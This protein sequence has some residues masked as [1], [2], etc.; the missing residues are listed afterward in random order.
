M[1]SNVTPTTCSSPPA[2]KRPEVSEG[3]SRREAT[4]RAGFTRAQH[5]LLCLILLAG[6]GR[7]LFW[8]VTIAV[9][10]PI[11]EM[12]HFG[13]IASIANGEGIPIVGEDLLPAEAL[14]LA[15]ASPTYGFRSTP[16]TSSPHDPAWGA[17]AQ[18][19]EGVQPPLYYALLA[20][21]Y[22]LA[23][24]LGLL[25]TVMGL[26]FETLVLSLLAVPLTALLARE[27]F[28]DRS[29]TW[30][31][32]PAL[33]VTLGA[34]NGDGAYITNDALVLPLSAAIMLVAARAWARGPT[35]GQAALMGAL[36]GLAFLGRANA[37]VLAPLV[38]LAL[39]GAAWRH[40]TP[41]ERVAAWAGIAVGIGLAFGLP[42]IAWTRLAYHG[43]TI[44]AEF[45]AILEPIVGR[46]PW[47]FEGLLDHLANA[48]RGWFDFEVLRPPLGGFFAGA[49]AVCVAALVAGLVGCARR[50][51]RYGALALVW[52][53]SCAPI[54]LFGM[55][56]VIQLVLDGNGGMVGRYLILTLPA[57][58]LLVAAGFDALLGAR[59]GAVAIATVVAASV[60]AG[61]WLERHYVDFVYTQEAGEG[62]APVV[63]QSWQD[64]WALVSSI[65]VVPPCPV[66]AITLTFAQQPPGSLQVGTAHIPL[67]EIAPL[68]VG[69]KQGTYQPRRPLS[70][71]F[72][73]SLPDGV[74][75]GISASERSARLALEGMPGD[76]VARLDCAVDDPNETRFSQLHA[77]AP[78]LEITYSRLMTA[79]LIWPLLAW[80]A[81]AALSRRAV[82]AAAEPPQAVSAPTTPGS[83]ARDE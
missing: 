46:Q 37:V 51:D 38:A 52:L 34:V 49:A 13:Y 7:G 35:L 41:L 69:A 70:Q 29:V 36:G 30:L 50:G 1:R 16:I 12:Q 28:P 8:I 14:A 48:T 15:K 45:S 21:V 24:P 62:V 76:P 73:V 57:L 39:I 42:W 32:A 60:T 19:Y 83:R 75:M 31:G 33:L 71:P 25:E 43:T 66:R 26:R 3:Q 74:A 47:T 53:A 17:G 65:E 20:P 10:N 82:R 18:Q 54:A 22:A 63:D 78:V 27:L 61:A 6:L 40:R 2:C 55:L 72:R 59:W 67:W 56:G 11:D 64:Q 80:G 68:P 23:R 4:L 79:P 77:L 44:A 9:W 81:V 58:A 5:L